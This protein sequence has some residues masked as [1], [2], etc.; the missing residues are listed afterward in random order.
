MNTQYDI[1]WLV[2]YQ[3]DERE[4]Q[5]TTPAQNDLMLGARF[6]YNDADGTEVLVGYVQDLDVSSSRSGFIEAS[7]RM[8]DNWKW[9]FEAYLFSTDEPT[10]I[11][12]NFRRDDYV[13]LNIEY[14]F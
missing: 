13:Q 9:R 2:E 6:V 1:G 7:S 4:E 11:L 14:Y 5:A 10:D 12:Y 3:Y 8:S